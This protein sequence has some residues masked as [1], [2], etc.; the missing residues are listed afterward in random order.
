[1]HSLGHALLALA[2]GA[3]MP[4]CTS[5][6]PLRAQPPTDLLPPA[7]RALVD[8]DARGPFAD[9]FCRH[10]AHTA[11]DPARDCRSWVVPAELLPLPRKTTGVAPP[12]RAV[13]AVVIVPGVFGECTAPWVQP[14]SADYAYLESRGLRVAVIPTAGRGSSEHNARIIGQ[15]FAH[16]DWRDVLVLAYSKGAQDFMQAAAAPD[17]ARWTGA[18]SAFV[19]VAGVVNGSPLAEPNVGWYEHL[20][21][22]LPLPHCGPSDGGAIRSLT[23][24]AALNVRARFEQAALPFKS[25][26]VVAMAVPGAVNPLLTPF[27]RALTRAD[28]RNDGQMLALDAILPHS[29]LLGTFAADHWAIALPF[30]ESD[31]AVMRP[32]S[33]RNAFPR[34][35]L[36]EAI[37][38]YVTHDEK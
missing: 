33:V 10:Y 38:D 1:M 28:P 18:V 24:R 13:T 22:H 14:F 20:M 12:P 4:G 16:L 5:I 31:A 17:A 30:E 35:P 29:V 2:F 23:Y 34:R 37:L 15:F 26:S 11:H 36:I 3:A 8:V 19:S 7:R 25:Y 27:Q 32:F 6:D 9:L 21:K